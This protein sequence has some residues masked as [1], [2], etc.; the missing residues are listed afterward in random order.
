MTSSSCFI[1]QYASCLDFIF[2]RKK[3]LFFIH[4]DLH[5]FLSPITISRKFLDTFLKQA[6]DTT[7]FISLKHSVV[8][9]WVVTIHTFIS[10]SPTLH[11]SPF[12][13]IEMKMEKR[14]YCTIK[15]KSNLCVGSE[16]DC[17]RGSDYVGVCIHN[18]I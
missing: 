16:R 11:I 5:I 13:T 10:F 9:L 4:L 17:C 7:S 2:I 1:C 14:K 3:N 18:W 12:F 8:M 15:G 6:A